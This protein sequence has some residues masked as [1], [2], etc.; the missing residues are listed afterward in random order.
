MTTSP[1]SAIRRSSRHNRGQY[2]KTRYMDDYQVHSA[3]LAKGNRHN[4]NSGVSDKDDDVLTGNSQ[5]T[6][7]SGNTDDEASPIKDKRINFQTALQ[8]FAAANEN[9]NSIVNK[10]RTPARAIV[11]LED[12]FLNLT[13]SQLKSPHRV[14][15]ANVV[16]EYQDS[17]EVLEAITFRLQQGVTPSLNLIQQYLV[18]FH[19]TFEINKVQLCRLRERMYQIL[20]RLMDVQYTPNTKNKLPIMSPKATAVIDNAT[21]IGIVTEVLTKSIIA[22]PSKIAE[23]AKTLNVPDKLL[24]MLKYIGTSKHTT[25]YNADDGPY[26]HELLY[27]MLHGEV[28]EEDGGIEDVIQ[29]FRR[30]ARKTKVLNNDSDN[31]DD[32]LHTITNDGNR[33]SEDQ[34]QQRIAEDTQ[35]YQLEQS[36]VLETNEG[37]SYVLALEK[38]DNEDDST[39]ATTTGTMVIQGQSTSPTT[40]QDSM[41]KDKIIPALDANGDTDGTEQHNPNNSNNNSTNATEL[42]KEASAASIIRCM[43]SRTEEHSNGQDDDP[44]DPNKRKLSTTPPDGMSPHKKQRKEQSKTAEEGKNSNVVASSDIQLVVQEGL[45]MV[46]QIQDQDNMLNTQHREILLQKVENAYKNNPYLSSEEDDGDEESS[47]LTDAINAMQGNNQDGSD[48]P[49]EDG[50]LTS[51]TLSVSTIDTVSN[52]NSWHPDAEYRREPET[53]CILGTNHP[54]YKHVM[55]VNPSGLHKK[56]FNAIA[57]ADIIGK[58]YD[59]DNAN[60][61]HVT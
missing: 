31:D 57:Y 17:D 40:N 45:D 11:V 24:P 48:D 39:G 20:L 49:S 10:E 44:E 35:G 29:R 60:L 43:S 12:E 36:F 18:K 6:T 54:A 41:D 50:S 23:G 14:K 42:P 58:K 25:A 52:F 27:K 4:H 1:S 30:I 38:C 5:K 19:G 16:T 53:D 32:G 8:M 61:V 28:D 21:L 46:G 37:E 47:K 2:N 26:V 13:P 33:E 7:I 51:D 22:S 34:D 56:V 55:E 3:G 15:T 9:K 59:S